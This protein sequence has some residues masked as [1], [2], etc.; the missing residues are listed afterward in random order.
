MARAL[1]KRGEKE[2]IR[3]GENERSRNRAEREQTYLQEQTQQE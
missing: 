3:N 1:C 2:R